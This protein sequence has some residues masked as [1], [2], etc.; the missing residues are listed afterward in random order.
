MVAII[1]PTKDRSEFI[2][3]LLRYYAEINCSH[4]IY[5]ADSSSQKKHI[6]NIKAIITK[7]SEDIEVIYSY[8]PNTNIEEAKRLTLEDNVKEKYAAYCGDDDFLIPSTLDECA[9]FLDNNKEYSNCHGTGLIFNTNDDPLKGPIESVV[10]YNLYANELSDPL[11]RL[12]LYFSEYW[13]IWSVRRTDE[14]KE[15]LRY[16]KDISVESFREITMGCLPIIYGKTKKV[17]SLYVVRQFHQSRHKEPDP[18]SAFLSK[19]WQS[20]FQQ[21]SSILSTRLCEDYSLN[22]NECIKAIEQ[23]FSIYYSKVLETRLNRKE[24]NQNLKLLSRS[25]LKNNFKYFYKNFY[26]RYISKGTNIEKLRNQKLDN[27]VEFS[28]V[29]IFIETYKK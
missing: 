29:D 25:F 22:K 24:T 18:V 15:S 14:F 26:L 6:D 20:S 12:K 17:D 28:K 8:Y 7:L 13:P 10:D 4:R 19:D 21:M 1:I 27:Y 3:R 11:S 23:S 16:L 9:N 5:I 2:E